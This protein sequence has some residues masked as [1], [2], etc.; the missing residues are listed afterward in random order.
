MQVSAGATE[1]TGT[2]FAVAAALALGALALNKIGP[3]MVPAPEELGKP[4]AEA[5]ARRIA[6]LKSVQLEK[7][8][9]AGKEQQD[10]DEP[11]HEAVLASV[12]ASRKGQ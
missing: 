10:E 8:F 3:S 5:E 6:H 11:E 2:V 9:Q 7:Q 12:K 1:M 4:E